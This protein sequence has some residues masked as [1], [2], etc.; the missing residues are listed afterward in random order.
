M[1]GGSDRTP[2]RLISQGC[3]G[4][5][6]EENKSG[7]RD[8]HRSREESLLPLPAPV[9]A[10]A[11]GPVLGSKPTDRAGGWVGITGSMTLTPHSPPQPR[12]QLTV[13]KHYM[14]RP[15]K[16]NTPRVHGWKKI[17][18]AWRCVPFIISSVEMRRRKPAV[19]TH[20][21]LWEAT[22]QAEE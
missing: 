10:R 18:C 19:S 1:G 12:H 21:D 14:C 4:I 5:T 20:K 16:I 17:Q 13:C 6:R 9:P 15:R 22:G 2:R 11:Q 3:Q 7:V 8:G